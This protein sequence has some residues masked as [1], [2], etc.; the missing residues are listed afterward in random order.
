MTWRENKNSYQFAVEIFFVCA[1]KKEEKNGKLDRK[2][3]K[4][5]V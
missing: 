4:E 3:L 5:K 2:Q 1:R